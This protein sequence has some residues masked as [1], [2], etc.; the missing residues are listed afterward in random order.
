VTYYHG[1]IRGL[2]PGDLI[3]PP[4]ETGA[5]SV[6]DVGAPTEELSIRV[7]QVHRKDRV[8]L[9]SDVFAARV[10]ASLHPNSR[11]RYGGD[12]YEVEPIGDVEPDPDY[13]VG[14]GGSV[15]AARAR[16]VAV[17]QRRVPRPI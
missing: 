1:G 11:R 7:A 17:I 15:Q 2:Q 6:A 8:Y 3:L 16:V 5:V 10:F 9:T 13:L 12:V 4:D 14:D